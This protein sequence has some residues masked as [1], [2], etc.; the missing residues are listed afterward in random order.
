MSVSALGCM[1]LVLFGKKLIQGLEEGC[2]GY[3]L[4]LFYLCFL[5]IIRL[6]SESKDLLSL[7]QYFSIGSKLIAFLRLPHLIIAATVLFL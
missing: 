1:V 7:A 3:L 5:F 2:Q 6:M 4:L